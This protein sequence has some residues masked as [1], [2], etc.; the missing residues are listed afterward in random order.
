MKHIKTGLFLAITSIIGTTLG[1]NNLDNNN[2]DNNNNLSTRQEDSS[3]LLA[4]KGSLAAACARTMT[5][6]P[7]TIKAYLKAL[8]DHDTPDNIPHDYARIIREQY[9]NLFSTYKPIVSGIVKLPSNADPIELEQDFEKKQCHLYRWDNKRTYLHMQT[10]D[11]VIYCALSKKGTELITKSS[12]ENTLKLLILNEEMD[13]FTEKKQFSVYN[14]EEMDEEI[15]IDDQ[16][17]SNDQKASDD[18]GEQFFSLADT[19]QNF[20]MLA[21]ASKDTEITIYSYDQAKKQ[22]QT[23]QTIELSKNFP[24]QT[25]ESIEMI[26]NG[27]SMIIQTSQIVDDLDEYLDEALYRFHVYKY[28]RDSGQFDLLNSLPATTTYQY[29]NNDSPTGNKMFITDMDNHQLLIYTIN[30]ATEKPVRLM[31]TITNHFDSAAF[32]LTNNDESLIVT[33]PTEKD[34]E[35][36][37]EQPVRIWRW[38]PQVNQY[39]L[40]QSLPVGTN[41]SVHSYLSDN[42]KILVTESSPLPPESNK[43]E[44]AEP[45]ALQEETPK[46]EKTTLT[47]WELNEKREKFHKINV[48]TEQDIPGENPH[49]HFIS[50]DGDLLLIHTGKGQDS[51]FTIWEREDKD[52]DL[53]MRKTLAQ[54]LCQKFHELPKR[55]QN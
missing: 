37:T 28:N 33:G 29:V 36:R 11:N 17:A 32:L 14:P 13:T 27:T 49:S 15:F 53:S 31:Q 3:R 47:V 23:I 48:L 22:T 26:H 4:K 30:N 1:N 55:E 10:I 54:I 46:S 19:G 18:M 45:W 39:R 21:V 42:G 38:N 12:N 8:E 9:P 34:Q 16:E 35:E 2:L 52:P 51:A 25:I 41:Q 5:Q 44:Q 6:N 7:E 43:D 40:Y 20:L 50:N 24:Q